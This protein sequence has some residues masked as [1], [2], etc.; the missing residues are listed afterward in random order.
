V[1]PIAWPSITIRAPDGFDLSFTWPSALPTSVRRI[2]SAVVRSDCAVQRGQVL[3]SA[4][5]S[6]PLS[7]QYAVSVTSR[8]PVAALP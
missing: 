7:N 3:R 5:A 2:S 8:A 1:T 4:T 6:W